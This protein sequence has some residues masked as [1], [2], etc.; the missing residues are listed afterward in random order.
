L[1]TIIWKLKKLKF[2]TKIFLVISFL[3]LFIYYL[4]TLDESLK[5]IIL[6]YLSG[7]LPKSVFDYL[8]EA[9]VSS[10][11]TNFFII[12]FLYISKKY[13]V[14]YINIKNLSKFYNGNFTSNKKS[15]DYLIYVTYIYVFWRMLSR[16][17]GVHS[18][19]SEYY[20]NVPRLY[21]NFSQVELRPYEL[22]SLHFIHRIVSIPN[23][24]TIFN[25]Q[26]FTAIV[27]IL[28]LYL[29][30]SKIISIIIFVNCMYLSGFVLM[31]NAELEATEIM[32]FSLFIIT[33][34]NLRNSDKWKFG[35]IGF[36]WFVGFYYVSSGLNKLIDVGL[37]FIWTLNLDEFRYVAALNSL[38]LDS[39]YA[40]PIFAELLIHPLISDF[41][42]LMTVLTELGFVL[43]FLNNKYS[44]FPLFGAILLHTSV[45]LMAGINF[46]GNSFFLIY[47]IYY[48]LN[49]NDN[50]IKKPKQNIT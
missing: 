15:Y 7:I 10:L 32:L 41:F 39:R 21:L 23:Y 49:G 25:L 12:I 30:Y 46:T 31:T 40:H 18:F 8:Q 44:I 5:F 19:V 13:W 34:T 45:F 43:L 35:L 50:S 38:S 26:I 22:T 36:S 6:N 3:I 27:C 9:N 1:L 4:N 37:S 17:Y 20:S 29:K 2:K 47:L 16:N 33:V 48:I 28:G 24:D 11:L 14:K 42:G